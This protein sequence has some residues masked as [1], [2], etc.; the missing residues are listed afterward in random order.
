VVNP[1]KL[2]IFML[3]GPENPRRCV[4]PFLVAMTALASEW[5]VSIYFACDGVLLLRR[6]AAESVVA[7]EGGRPLS[8]FMQDTM[9][10]GGKMYACSPAVALHHLTMADLIEGI[11]AGGAAALLDET[12]DAD[13]VLTI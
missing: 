7:A 5:N 4:T 10:M 11:E 13:T 3:T 9:E 6:G 2:V 8:E 12:R 1:P